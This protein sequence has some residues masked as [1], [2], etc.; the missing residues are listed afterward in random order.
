MISNTKW[1][2]V[3]PLSI[4]LLYKGSLVVCTETL[5]AL[6]SWS[7]TWHLLLVSG[8]KNALQNTVG[9]FNDHIVCLTMNFH[10]VGFKIGDGPMMTCVP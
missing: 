3:C 9:L 6:R 10:K 8:Q 2:N 7:G 5:V 1:D 4:F